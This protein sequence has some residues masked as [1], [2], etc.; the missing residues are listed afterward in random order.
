MKQRNQRLLDQLGFGERRTVE[1]TAPEE[2]LRESGVPFYMKIDVEGGEA[3]VINGLKSAVLMLSFKVNL[4]GF[5]LEAR[6]CIA[7][8]GWLTLQDR[9]N[10]IADCEGGMLLKD[11]G[12]TVNMADALEK[13]RLPLMEIFRKPRASLARLRR[14]TVARTCRT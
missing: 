9:W 1:V 3:T 8:L 5:W 7:L 12:M 2:W 13:F 11:W 14:T 4:P 10:F 6:G